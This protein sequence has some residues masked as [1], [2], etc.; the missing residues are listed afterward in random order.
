[1]QF[2]H[3]DLGQRR[4]GETVEVMLTGNAANVRLMDA[5][6]FEN[7]RNGLEYRYHGGLVTK[8]PLRLPIPHAGNWYIAVDMKGLTGTVRSAVRVLP[9]SAGSPPDMREALA[10]LSVATAS[11]AP[12]P[13]AVPPETPSQQ[14]EAVRD[15]DVFIAHAGEDRGAFVQPLA[16]ALIN[17]GLTV[18]YEECELK[19]GDSLHLH[20]DTG[21]ARSRFGVVVL[22][23]SFFEKGWTDDELDGLASRL[24]TGE[25]LLLPIWYEI[26]KKE[27][28]RYNRSLA[29]NAA[30]DTA[31]QSIEEIAADICE[32]G[33]Y[34]GRERTPGFRVARS[35]WYPPGFRAGR[36]GL[37]C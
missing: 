16:N 36:W 25:Q 26:A 3:H 12:V 4:G 15:Y 18:W 33:F 21:L 37:R 23:H 20:F 27:L 8:S 2:I 11:A 13:S 29:G 31:T 17:N 28:I 32:A 19:Q 9:A 5:V 14:G 1:M 34:P 10:A 30:R 24:V 22:S 7:Y 35:D 6:H